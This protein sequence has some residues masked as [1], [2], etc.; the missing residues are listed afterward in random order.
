MNDFF[1]YQSNYI[2]TYYKE[3]SDICISI[4]E[5]MNYNSDNYY[6]YNIFTLTSC[7]FHFYYMFR[8]L[9]GVIK[10]YNKFD[11]EPMWFQAWLNVH[12]SNKLLDWHNHAGD[13][14]NHG[15]DFHGYI[16]ID[17]KGCDTIFKNYNISNTYGSI[18]IGRSDE[19]HK[20][21]T[22]KDFEGKRVTIG[23]DV[24]KNIDMKGYRSLIPII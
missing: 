7:S 17:P 2:R 16:S 12:E 10:A 22:S 3:I 23:F 11:I 20:V 1:M 15:C 9:I 19:Y 21:E 24:T 5:E 8:E 14:N 18:Y 4:S 6:E 13:D